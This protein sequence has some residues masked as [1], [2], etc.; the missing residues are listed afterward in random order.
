MFGWDVEQYRGVAILDLAPLCSPQAELSAAKVIQTLSRLLHVDERQVR[1]METTRISFL[2][3]ISGVVAM[4]APK[5]ETLFGLRFRLEIQWCERRTAAEICEGYVDVML[6]FRD[7]M[8]YGSLSRAL[9]QHGR[10]IGGAFQRC[11]EGTTL[12]HSR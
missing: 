7:I 11:E 4:E 3:N 6:Q 5:K 10:V 9:E 12:C 2:N 1:C 8:S